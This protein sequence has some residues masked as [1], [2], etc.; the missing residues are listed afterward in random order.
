MSSHII[1][2]QDRRDSCDEY[3]A[4]HGTAFTCHDDGSRSSMVAVVDENVIQFYMRDNS[5]R[6]MVLS[7]FPPD[8]VRLLEMLLEYTKQLK[9]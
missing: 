1:D 7:M 8:V 6:E 2:S 9:P 4:E 5:E 3:A